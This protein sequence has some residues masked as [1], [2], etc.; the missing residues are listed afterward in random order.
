MKFKGG[1]YMSKN[2]G[3]GR[4]RIGSKSESIDKCNIASH[5]KQCGRPKKVSKGEH[6]QT[7]PEFTK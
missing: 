7:K 1:I 2:T 5:S 3:M 4:K 6:L